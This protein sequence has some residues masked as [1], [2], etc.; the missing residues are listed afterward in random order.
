MGVNLIDILNYS[1]LENAKAIAGVSGLN[2]NIQKISVYDRDFVDDLAYE[3]GILYISTLPHLKEQSN[4]KK[5]NWF[6]Q[7]VACEAC[8]L[9]LPE[10]TRKILTED[11][12]SFCNAVRFPVILVNNDFTYADIIEHISILIY[13]NKITAKNE[14]RLQRIMYEKLSEEETIQVLHAISP[15]VSEKILVLAIQCNFS[16]ALYE[17]DL[18]RANNE[19]PFWFFV[20]FEEYYIVAVSGVDERDIEK[21]K[22]GVLSLVKSY[23]SN[24]KIGESEVFP[25]GEFCEAMKHA[26]LSLETAVLTGVESGKYEPLSD[27]ALVLSA[28]NSAAQAEFYRKFVRLIQEND[29]NNRMEYLR[30]IRSYVEA[31]G[32]FALAAEKEHQTESTLR[33][34]INRVK[35]ILGVEDDIVKFHEI[36]SLFVIIEKII[37]K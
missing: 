31:K 19:S 26:L 10:E 25:L 20:P 8:G 34:R 35:S 18:L 21:K 14:E 24:T 17:R 9:I 11:I 37:K 3:E 6:K 12:I 23:M 13:Y 5:L 33:Y 16:S 28:K 15:E 27:Y 36:I 30:C 4:E 7:I 1:G 32:D 2:R 22:K 29:L